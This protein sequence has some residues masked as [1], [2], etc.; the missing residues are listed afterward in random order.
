MEQYILWRLL[1]NAEILMHSALK[2]GPRLNETSLYKPSQTSCR[3]AA[4][5]C[6]TSYT[7]LT[8]LVDGS[9][10]ESVQIIV[11]Y[12]LI[13]SPNGTNFIYVMRLRL[14]PS[15]EGGVEAAAADLVG[16]PGN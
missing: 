4:L 10:S 3:T 1:T 2:H 11:S 14:S 12:D 16:K 8:E 15:T 13:N 9:S 6:S 5:A 7:G